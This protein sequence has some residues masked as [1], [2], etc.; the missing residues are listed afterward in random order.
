VQK[1]TSGFIALLTNTLRHDLKKP[2]EWQK[3]IGIAKYENKLTDIH[4][5]RTSP[6][7]VRIIV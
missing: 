1:N 4:R 5:T 6:E 3:E 7:W 2:Y